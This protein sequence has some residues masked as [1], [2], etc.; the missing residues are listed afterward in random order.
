MGTFYRP[1]NAKIDETKSDQ[2]FARRIKETVGDSPIIKLPFGVFPEW[3]GYPSKE[4]YAAFRQLAFEK[5]HSIFPAVKGSPESY[6]KV[7]LF[8][9]RIPHRQSMRDFGLRGVVIDRMDYDDQ[10]K[11]A[12]QALSLKEALSFDSANGRF[13]FISL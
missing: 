3:P 1:A 12:I 8:F 4:S 10:G 13:K 2:E 11:E 9:G 7:E 6:R 5:I